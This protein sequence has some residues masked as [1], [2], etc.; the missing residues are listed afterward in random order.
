MKNTVTLQVSDFKILDFF[1]L[2]IPSL[3]GFPSLP[4]QFSQIFQSCL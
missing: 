3:K 2:E 1:E 4:K